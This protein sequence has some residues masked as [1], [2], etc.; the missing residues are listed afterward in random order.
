MCLTLGCG[1]VQD[2]GRDAHANWNANPLMLLVCSVNTP[3]DHNRSHL[4]SLCVRVLCEWGLMPRRMQLC[5]HRD[6]RENTIPY[7]S[8]RVL[9]DYNREILHIYK[10][11]RELDSML[12]AC[13]FTDSTL[14][15]NVGAI[16]TELKK[17]RSA[18]MTKQ[19]CDPVLLTPCSHRTRDA[20]VMRDDAKNGTKIICCFRCCCSTVQA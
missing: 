9:Y 4:L 12:N 7:P 20:D 10:N 16:K 17:E 11:C 15:E 14:A 18:K 19:V 13:Y 3:I 6:L 1:V 2:A 5:D 8:E